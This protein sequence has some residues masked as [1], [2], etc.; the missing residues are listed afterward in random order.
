MNHPFKPGR[1]NTMALKNR[2]V[3]SA[4][5]EGMAADDGA[6][7][8]KLLEFLTTLAKGGVGLVISSHAYVQARGQ[9][10]PWQLGI[11]SDAMLSGLNQMTDAVHAQGAKIVAQLAHAGRFAATRLTGETPVVVSDFSGLADLECHELTAD[12]IR[13]LVADFAA[14]ATRAKAAGFDGVQ[15]HSAHGYLLSQFL[16]P[17]FNRRR[18][19]YGG[20]IANRCRIHQEILQAMRQSLGP[21]FP[22]LMKINGQDY[23]ES[24]LSRADA[25][26]IAKAL[27]DAGLDAIEV[28]GGLHTGGK[29]SPSRPGIHTAEKEAYFRQD[30]QAIKQAAGIPVILV[31][32]IRSLEVAEAVI[33]EGVADF[34]SMSRPLVREPDLIK[35]WQNGDR[36]KSECLSDNLCFQP[37]RA[38]EGLYCLSA[39]R[40][41]EKHV[42]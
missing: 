35:R 10:G 30:A 4:T 14:A 29:L 8:P 2:F 16:S 11:H 37:A 19:V 33:Q 22:I 5:W 18:D 42:G 28:S 3:R 38:G 13:S 9:A 24:G 27:A 39:R 36:R 1:I 15:L 41:S 34:V 31:G 23:D 40:S 20:D 26:H 25:V 6:V 12:D 32:G 17:H 7:T 21:E